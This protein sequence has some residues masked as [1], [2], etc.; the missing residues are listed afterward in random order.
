MGA[1]SR[2]VASVRKRCARSRCS[3]SVRASRA[4]PHGHLPLR[5]PRR[6]ALEVT[7]ARE[8]RRRGRRSPSR[9][10][11]IAVRVVAHEREP[12]RN[13]R[14]RDAESLA[15]RRLAADLARAPVQLDHPVTPH[16]L[17][18][19]LVRRAHQHLAD[20][21]VGRGHGRCGGQRV[22]GL[23]L[24]HRPDDHAERAQRVLQRVELGAESGIHALTGLVARPER[25]A[26]RFDDVIGRHA[27]VRRARLEHRDDGRDHA[28]DRP[29]LGTDVPAEGR[30]GEEIAKQL[31][32]PVD[33]VDDHGWPDTPFSRIDQPR[34]AR[35]SS[36][37][38]PPCRR[39]SPQAPDHSR[40]RSS[41]STR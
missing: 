5:G 23:E 40:R 8:H 41:P 1:S 13:R 16:A 32:R 26:K 35:S 22:V 29:Q 4:A 9:Q 20:A 21:R 15:H 17:R 30:R 2:R 10:A 11:R 7:V 37:R 3:A 28:V 25:V 6:D 14:G 36:R 38:H 12:V 31:E 24:N 27:Q 39:E 33:Q 34:R 19:I 18:Q